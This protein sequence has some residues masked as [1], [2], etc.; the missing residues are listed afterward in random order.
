MLRTTADLKCDLKMSQ[1]ELSRVQ[2]LLA[3]QSEQM[4][5]CK[6]EESYANAQNENL[7]KAL[8]ERAAAFE[9]G[10]LLLVEAERELEEI[11]EKYNARLQQMEGMGEII[12]RLRAGI[13]NPQRASNHTDYAMI[14]W[15]SQQQGIS[16]NGAVE[17]IPPPSQPSPHIVAPSPAAAMAPAP[18]DGVLFIDVGEFEIRIGVWNKSSRHIEL[19]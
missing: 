6:A 10:G 13:S 15:Q 16:R 14:E 2:Q 19:W 17:R 4:K 12:E 9:T 8:A 1:D 18:C 11:R 5:R 7:R 3:A